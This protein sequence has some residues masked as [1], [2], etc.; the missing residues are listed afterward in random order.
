M[1]SLADQR[2]ILGIDP[3][4][5][6]LAFVFFEGGRLIDW[7]TRRIRGKESAAFEAILNLCPADVL[8][9]EDATALG[10]ERRPKVVRLLALL[11]RAAEAKGLVVV[12]VSRFD[13]RRGWSARGVTRKH[14]VA[15][16]IAEDFPVLEPSVPRP[17]K[18]YM[19]EEARVQVFDAASLVLHA[20]GT[21]ASDS[22]AA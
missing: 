11:A 9:L 4:K 19:D 14:A 22:L 3:T 10:C 8:V 17:R 21:V 6:G 7:G 5:R 15:T 16:A 1:R 13:V 20:F 2:A 18:S 12:K